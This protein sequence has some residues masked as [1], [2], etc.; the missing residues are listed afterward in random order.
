MVKHNITQC[1]I[2]RGFCKS[3]LAYYIGVNRSYVTKLEQGRLQPSGEMMLR[4]ARVLRQPV[5]NI[6]QLVEEG[7]KR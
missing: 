4:I 1:R 3:K 2:E 6:F 7:G 5:E